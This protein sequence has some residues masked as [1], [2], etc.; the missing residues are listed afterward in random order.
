MK[1]LPWNISCGYILRSSELEICSWN[2]VWN[3]S[4]AKDS[5]LNFQSPRQYQ[6]LQFPTTMHYSVV[7]WVM[8]CLHWSF[9]VE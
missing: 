1:I 6:S 8:L 4:Q 3:W 2:T 5:L 9:S 7:S